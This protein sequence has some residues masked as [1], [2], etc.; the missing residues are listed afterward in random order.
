MAR[1]MPE[2]NLND[3]VLSLGYLS[4]QA[5]EQVLKQ[6]GDDLRR[7]NIMKHAANLKEIHSDILLPGITIGTSPDDF[8]PIKQMHLVRFEGTRWVRFDEIIKSDSRD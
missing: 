6:A 8:A 5:L 3:S 7:E 1:Y 2:G 4:A